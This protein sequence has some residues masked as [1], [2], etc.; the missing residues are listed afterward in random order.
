MKE[1]VKTMLAVI[2]ALIVMRVL[3]MFMFLFM[4]LSA[5]VSGVSSSPSIPKEGVLDI[6]MS[7]FEIK[8]QSQEYAMPN[9][10]AGGMTLPQT[11]ISLMNAVS[12][13]EAAAADPGI[14]YIFLRPEKAT[15]G[16]AQAEEFRAALKEFRRSGK[17]VIVWLEGSA[18]GS[19]Y[20]ATVA[21]KIYM[22]SYHGYTYQLLGLATQM[23]F[24]KDV[25]D[26]LGV[27]VQLIRHGK[28]K[29]A[30]EMFI[31][32]SASAE[33][34]EQNQVMIKSAWK[35]LSS[36]IAESRNMSEDSFNAIVDN[37]CLVV[38]EDFL[39]TGLVDDIMTREDL[40]AKLCAL[41]GVEKEDE[42]KLISFSGYVESKVKSSVK[43]NVAVLYAEGEI[44]D[45]PE[46][47]E[48]ISGDRFVKEINKVANN[49]DIKAVV[50]RVN[51]PG[52]SVSAS[53]KIRTALDSLMARKPLVA[54]FGNYAASGGYWISNGCEKIYADANTITGSIG[55]FSMIPE[56]SKTTK[57]IG[58]N[59]ET[60]GSNKHSD[61]FSLMRPFDAA[62]L[63]YMQASVEDIYE[64]FVNLVADG[65]KM[66]PSAVDAIAQGRVWMGSDALNIG[67]VD[68]IGNLN[69]A[70]VYAAGLAGIGPDDYKVAT[71]PAPL[72]FAQMI[73]ESLGEGE[74]PSI[75]AGTPFEGLDKEVSSV[76]LGNPGKPMARMPYA[77]D[78]K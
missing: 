56:F 14:K 51:S 23:M 39:K 25:L 8:E 61:M 44:V 76:I 31:R 46:D 34:R 41:A 4:F 3:A 30:G 75:L 54:S 2:C 32:S 72:S 42:L 64:A 33:N 12:A 45:D 36:A 20:L 10:S 59:F 68:E 21:D 13:I 28:Y 35:T 11:Q 66:A 50:L 15:L 67:L 5:I 18:N 52:G 57:K 77:Y 38:P 16:L 60:V 29:S 7:E 69:D 27:N 48:N 1:F 40:V 62:E 58:V 63:N 71:Y 37:L 47:L 55:V 74:G 53:V 65:R 19:Y 73:L 6:N 43:A 9:F 17:P 49:D 26:K 78:I 24:V 22:S 70:I